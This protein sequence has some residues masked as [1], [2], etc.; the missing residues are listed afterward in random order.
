[1]GVFMTF[2]SII[3]WMVISVVA[4]VPLV[5]LLVVAGVLAVGVP[6]IGYPVT[7]TVWFGVDLTLRPPTDEDF[8][9]AQAWL[10]SGK[11]NPGTH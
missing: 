3:V 1:M 10:D 11:P 4:S 2:G 9:Q 8:S 5:P 6:V 7:Y